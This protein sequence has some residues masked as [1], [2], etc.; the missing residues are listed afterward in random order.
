M[1][2]LLQASLFFAALEATAPTSEAPVSALHAV[3]LAAVSPDAEAA[4][5]HFS[6]D[7]KYDEKFAAA[8]ELQSY[9]DAAAFLVS[10]LA[11]STSNRN[12]LEDCYAFLLLNQG[13]AKHPATRELVVT[14]GL[15]SEVHSITYQCVWY[16]GHYR[17]VESR[18]LLFH[19]MLNHQLDRNTRSLAAQ[20]LGQLGDFRAFGPLLEACR[21][22]YYARRLSGN[23]GLKGL[24][25][26]NLSD[27]G[28]YRLLEGDALGGALLPSPVTD[29]LDLAYWQ[30]T[31]FTALR[32]YLGWLKQEHPDWYV[33]AS[34]SS[35]TKTL[36]MFHK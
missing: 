14:H 11:R 35:G 8:Q 30:A 22:D 4:L 32:D 6:Q 25:G 23:V 16:A 17:V 12:V 28:D 24:T 7:L 18:E 10:E 34:P 13:F 27:F 20:S 26:K 29:S 21:S 19:L 36:D 33:I 1:L 31:R 15:D 2:T 9:G 3:Q 5:R